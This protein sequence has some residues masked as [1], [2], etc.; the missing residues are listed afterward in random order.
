MVNGKMK[1]TG[2]EPDMLG[3]LSGAGMMFTD[4]AQ[5]I[6]T[7]KAGNIREFAAY[8]NTS[9]Y[10]SDRTSDNKVDVAPKYE[11]ATTYNRLV[12]RTSLPAWMNLHNWKNRGS[13][14]AAHSRP[15]LSV[16]PTI[17]LNYELSAMSTMQGT[18][19]FRDRHG[20]ILEMLTAPV[21][22]DY[23]SMRLRSGILSRSRTLSSRLHYGFKSPLSMW[24]GR[25]DLEY[26]RK[27]NNLMSGQYVS[28]GLIAASTYLMPNTHDSFSA[29]AGLSKRI[30]SQRTNLSLDGSWT[31]SRSLTEQNDLRVRHYGNNYTLVPK[32]NSSPLD[33]LE[34]S[35]A[36]NLSMRTTRYLDTKHSS[37]SQNHNL[38]LKFY[39]LHRWEINLNSDIA[40]KEIA[41]GAYKT[42]ALFDAGAVFKHRSL[43]LGLRLHNLLITRRYTYTVFN[44]LDSYTYSYA[45]RPREL[46]LSITFM[47]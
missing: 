21:M 27:W 6:L 45:L 9:H 39:P 32:I 28:S 19:D 14:P 38:K 8:Y 44:G 20:D 36:L 25:A 42:M 46:Q 11:Y 47:K 29:N 16:A 18:V 4:K 41:A 40:R 17:Y 5:T 13:I 35:Y 33:W 34:L 10:R 3:E 12:L 24:N 2:G 37:T 1:V 31:W 7:V 30:A 15:L 26:S 43:R 23:M 22:T